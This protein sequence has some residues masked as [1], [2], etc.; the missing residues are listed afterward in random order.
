MNSVN[1]IC[2]SQNISVEKI[3]FV[4]PSIAVIALYAPLNIVQGIY[5]KYY[6]LTLASIA[7]VMLFTRL[8]DAFTDPLIGYLSDKFLLKNGTRKPFIILGG[9]ITIISGY[10]LYTPPETVSLTYFGFWICLFFLGFT[11]YTIPHLAWGGEIARGTNDKNQIYNLRAA[12]G[13]TGLVLFYSLPLLPFWESSEINPEK[14]HVSAIISGAL[15][16]PLIY[17]CVKHVPNGRFYA[18]QDKRFLALNKKASVPQYRLKETFVSILY[19]HPLRLFLCAFVFSGLGLGMWLSLLFIYVDVYLGMGSVFSEVFLF[20]LIIGIIS[21]L[22][23]IRVIN[24]VGKK[25][26]WLIAMT[27]GIVS[28]IY[29]GQ[30]GPENI[31]YESLLLLLVINT[32]CF[33]CMEALPASILTD[34]VDYTS[35]KFRV[36]RGST[37]FALFLLVYKSAFAVG[38]AL[39][40]AIV[41]WHGFDPA[42]IHQTLEGTTGL[43]VAMVG[44]PVIFA[45]LSMV[46]IILYPISAK[47]YE[48]IR[49]R[50]VQLDERSMQKDHI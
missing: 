44:L 21:S 22:L 38:G 19:N 41:G 47:R 16:V 18:A 48:I 33:V 5:A 31:T 28:F 9:I 1:S 40:L 49:Q 46:F 15:M 50:L 4:L 17:L 42:V 30:L 3:Y 23:W 45:L 2:K 36:Y 11:L 43:K 27:L 20:S 13:Y 24:L 12:A 10:F 32:L 7:S 37:Y 8:L 34:I 29:T 6:G 14:L 35:L 25:N 26:T 39:G